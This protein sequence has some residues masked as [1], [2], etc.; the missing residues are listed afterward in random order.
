MLSILLVEDDPVFR[1]VLAE[2]LSDNYSCHAVK[3]VEEAIERLNVERFGV[4]IT[5]ISMPG[6]SG[7]E[8]LCH[9][10]QN[11]PETQVVMMSGIYDG[12]YV[13]GLLKMGAFDFLEKPFMLEDADRTV[14]RAVKCHREQSGG[15]PAPTDAA[16]VEEES[17]GR[18]SAIFSSMQLGGIFSLP[19]VLEI[20]QRGKMNGYIE[21]HWDNATI[22]RAEH[23]GRFNDA[24]GRLD[25]AVFQCG[26]WLYLRD[27]LIIDAVIDEAED[28]PH[29]RDPEQSLTLLVKLATYIGEGVRAWGFSMSEMTRPA[30]LSVWDNSGKVFSIITRDEQGAASDG[31]PAPEPAPD[32]LLLEDLGELSPV[33]TMMDNITEQMGLLV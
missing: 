23:I 25:E 3:N 7:L 16:A 32:P 4:V 11:W 26:G 19:E 9:V 15:E 30:T 12:E 14:G 18:H 29:W 17:A 13:K 2:F 27:G 1:E 8:L 10:K 31:E 24:A 22:K 6:K 21:L 33:E 20:A 5:D 28:S